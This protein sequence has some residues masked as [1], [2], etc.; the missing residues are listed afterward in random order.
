[1]GWHRTFLAS[2]CGCA[3]MPAMW[4]GAAPI[5]RA[6]GS[7]ENEAWVLERWRILRAALIQEPVRNAAVAVNPAVAKKRPV[8]ADILQVF[9]VT[10]TDQDFFFIMRGLNND[11]SKRVAEERASPEFKA[12]ALRAIAANVAELLAYSIHHA[13]KNS[14][15]D[16]V[17]ALNGAPGVML[18]DAEFGFFIRM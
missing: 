4:T 17:R 9:Q 1:M 2:H 5:R 14:V 8:A 11:A 7:Q 12:L 15:G 16:T 6:C 18:H 13:D 10:L 3:A